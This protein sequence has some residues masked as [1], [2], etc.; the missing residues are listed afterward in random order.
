VTV[1]RENTQPKK[2][3]R[4]HPQNERK[5]QQKK[6]SKGFS[7]GK[8]GFGGN[9]KKTKIKWGK[10]GLR[11]PAITI[12]QQKKRRDI[13]GWEKQFSSIRRT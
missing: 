10:E 9:K 6:S 1:K 5:Y 7:Y 11:T 8:K 12:N 13:G 3:K 4:K 2:G